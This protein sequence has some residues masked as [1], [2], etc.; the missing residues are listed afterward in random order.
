LTVA[1]IAFDEIEAKVKS[2]YLKGNGINA[3]VE[4]LRFTWG[5]PIRTA[6]DQYRIYTAAR[7][8]KKARRLIE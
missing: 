1:Y 7:D 4:P 5:I 3:L 8:V 6:I 2:E